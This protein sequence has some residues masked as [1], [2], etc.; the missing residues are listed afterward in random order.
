MREIQPRDAG[1][2]GYIQV[3]D[4]GCIET[5]LKELIRLFMTELEFEEKDKLREKEFRKAIESKKPPKASQWKPLSQGERQDRYFG[6]ARKLAEKILEQERQNYVDARAE[7]DKKLIV[8]ITRKLAFMVYGVNEEGKPTKLKVI[9]EKAD[10][11]DG[12]GGKRRQDRQYVGD[13]D[14]E[15]LRQINLLKDRLQQLRN[16]VTYYPQEIR[17]LYNEA[18]DL[19]TLEYEYKKA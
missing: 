3:W 16:F 2:L 13:Y 10:I 4:K 1:S 6:K 14:I 15:R 12:R 5:R 11:P 17:K 9:V 18:L 19:V 7:R 8:E